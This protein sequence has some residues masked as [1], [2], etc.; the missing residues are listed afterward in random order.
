MNTPTLPP[1]TGD[2]TMSQVLQ[3]SLN[4]V[5]AVVIRA[6]VG[7]QVTDLAIDKETFHLL[8]ETGD[9]WK[10]AYW[11]FKD[12]GGV[13]L[14]TKVNDVAI[15]MNPVESRQCFLRRVIGRILLGQVPHERLQRFR[16]LGTFER[17][18]ADP[19][20]AVPVLDAP[21]GCFTSR[22]AMSAASMRSSCR[23]SR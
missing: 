16:N 15:A 11:E 1:L 6:L 3:L 22:S 9:T 2:M 10:R 21:L 5:S 23:R 13:I 20:Q 14:P 7:T 19:V 12:F 18:R 17:E 8:Q 4:P